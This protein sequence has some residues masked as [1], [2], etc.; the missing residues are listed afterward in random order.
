MNSDYKGVLFVVIQAVM[1][2]GYMIPILEFTSFCFPKLNYVFFILIFLGAILVLG[3]I[4]Q[5][6]DQL[7][8]FPAPKS[9]GRLI[10]VGFYKISRHPI[11]TGIL[12]IA[13]SYAA[14]SCSGFKLVM[15]VGLLVL[16]YFKSS[17]E[18]KLL[19]ARFPE[20]IH[21]QK[22]VGRFWP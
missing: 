15:S 20:Y 21:Y 3:A 6:R 5:L 9:D 16:F 8:P 12:L 4:L 1:F 22:K 13:F 7:S 14:Y 2:V 18:E 19:L 11:Y 17:Y 10:Q